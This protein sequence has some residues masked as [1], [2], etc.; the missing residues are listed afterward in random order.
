M[1][2]A[3][4]WLI[5][6]VVVVGGVFLLSR[7]KGSEAVEDKPDAVTTRPGFGETN[8][9]YLADRCAAIDSEFGRTQFLSQQYRYKC[10]GT[11]TVISAEPAE[12]GLVV[13][14]DANGDTADGPEVTAE[15]PSARLKVEKPTGGEKVAFIG[16]IVKASYDGAP[17]LELRNT[18]LTAP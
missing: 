2:K 4:L 15:V 12:D 6:L 13:Y 17:I 8:Y 16:A 1:N 14:I 9:K 10:S 11:G 18:T 3:V 7:R 5:V